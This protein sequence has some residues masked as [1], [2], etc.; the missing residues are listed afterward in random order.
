MTSRAQITRLAQR[1]E[2]LAECTATVDRK[3]GT[4]G[5]GLCGAVSYERPCG[6]HSVSAMTEAFASGRRAPDEPLP[7][8]D[9]H[10]KQDFSKMIAQHTA[11][12]L[13]VAARQDAVDL[14]AI[15]ETSVSR[16][17]RPRPTRAGHLSIDV[18]RPAHTRMTIDARR[19][20][21]DLTSLATMPDDATRVRAGVRDRR[22]S[23][24]VF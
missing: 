12:S 18:E 10:P 19:T 4:V 5:A 22:V 13:R 8:V 23:G 14:Q 17:A 16:A 11:K 20:S 21:K 1:C 9:G 7:S 24:S 3:I 15:P 2:D 6:R